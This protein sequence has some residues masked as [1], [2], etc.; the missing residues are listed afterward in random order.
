M[1]R[2][3]GVVG[4]IACPSEGAASPAEGPQGARTFRRGAPARVLPT[5]GG[6][7]AAVQPCARGAAGAF[8]PKRAPDSS[9]LTT[10][11]KPVKA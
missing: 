1:G 2:R 11:Y 6:G 3:R 8:G 10:S 7:E 9:A 4:E 5:W